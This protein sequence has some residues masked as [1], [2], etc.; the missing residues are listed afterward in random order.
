MKIIL[1]SHGELCQGML[2]TLEMFTSIDSVYA[3]SLGSGGVVEFENKLDE[4]LSVDEEY[5]VLT[6]IEGGS[7]Y[8]TVI[9]YR[10]E[11]NIQLEIVSGIN[12]PMA[13]EAVLGCELHTLSELAQKVTATAIS[14][15]KYLKMTQLENSE[16]E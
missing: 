14:S 13:I 4:I 2:N 7:P 1:T 3:I 11:H 5:L 10:L 12:L 6:D 16:D 8:Q 15:I 9:R